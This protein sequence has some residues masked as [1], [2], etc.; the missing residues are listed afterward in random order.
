MAFV[1]K[2]P[3]EKFGSVCDTVERPLLDPLADQ[4]AGNRGFEGR[5]V[6]VS[7]VHKTAR[8]QRHPREKKGKGRPCS[9]KVAFLISAE[10]KPVKGII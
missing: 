7:D 10:V 6:Y 2:S 1:K 9:K 3:M 8:V 5:N 4:K